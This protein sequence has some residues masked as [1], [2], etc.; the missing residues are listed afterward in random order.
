[1]SSVVSL[2]DLVATAVTIS[3]F[4]LQFHHTVI[5]YVV[6]VSKSEKLQK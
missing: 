4:V 6:G 2:G 1:M 3:H 5:Y